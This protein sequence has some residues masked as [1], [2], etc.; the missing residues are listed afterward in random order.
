MISPRSRFTTVAIQ[1][2]TNQ[3]LKLKKCKSGKNCRW[4][5]F[6]VW[7]LAE[8]SRWASV[9]FVLMSERRRCPYKARFR[10]PRGGEGFVSRTGRKVPEKV[11]QRGKQT[12]GRDCGETAQNFP[13]N[14]LKLY[15]SNK[16]DCHTM[17]KYHSSLFLLPC[18]RLGHHGRGHVQRLLLLL[19]PGGDDK[20]ASLQV[21]NIHR[22]HHNI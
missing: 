4:R 13:F 9:T 10:L 8:G 6:N 15:H 19:L 17:Y 7:P 16:T 1:L 5:P 14:V 2:N 11:P 21:G 18:R 3:Y 22:L 12:R 20:G